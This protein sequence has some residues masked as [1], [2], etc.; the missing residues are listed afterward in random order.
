MMRRI[1]LVKVES[2]SIALGRTT[3]HNIAAGDLQ[4]AV[5]IYAV[6]GGLDIQIAAGDGD[7]AVTGGHPAKSAAREH[8]IPTAATAIIGTACGI[9]TIIGSY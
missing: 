4:S 3:D 6:T 7:A 5:G 2:R 9:D 1:C 8:L